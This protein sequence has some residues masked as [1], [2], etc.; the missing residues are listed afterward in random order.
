MCVRLPQPPLA[1][2]TDFAA[3]G[4]RLGAQAAEGA[5]RLP[6][7][8]AR[9]TSLAEA[10]LIAGDAAR[11]FVRN[12]ATETDAEHFREGFRRALEAPVMEALLKT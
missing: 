11:Q 8:P 6:A 12:G 10:R 4:A 7:G 1:N 5:R 9:E 3:W 2:S